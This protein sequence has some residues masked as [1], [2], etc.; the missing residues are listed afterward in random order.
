MSNKVL[1]AAPKWLN[2]FPVVDADH[3]AGLEQDAAIHEF[4]HKMPRHEAE[5][6]AHAEYRTA[7]L[8][9]AA[10]HHLVG[11]T[12]AH[13]AGA[14]EDAKKHAAV[15]G[16]A[17]KALGHDDVMNPPPGVASKAKHTPA[18]VY[19]FKAHKGDAFALPET[20]D[21]PAPKAE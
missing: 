13:A 10:A 1:D 2:K 12:A 14:S 21:E 8:E 16:V 3:V 6:R 18:P 7:Q 19:K 20:K 4:G 5:A 15:Y 11:L 17:L 9:E